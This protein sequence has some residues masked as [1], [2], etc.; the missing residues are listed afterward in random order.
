MLQISYQPDSVFL[1][2]FSIKHT[3]QLLSA[4]SEQ[5][6][7]LNDDQFSYLSI[8]LIIELLRKKIRNGLKGVA[9]NY[10]A[11]PRSSRVDFHSGFLISPF[12]YICMGVRPRTRTLGKQVDDGN[13]FQKFLFVS[14][15]FDQLYFNCTLICYKTTGCHLWP[16]CRRDCEIRKIYQWSLCAIKNYHRFYL[17]GSRRRWLR[18][19]TTPCFSLSIILKC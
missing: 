11:C 2:S 15:G 13:A 7:I 5:S 19:I 12:S 4:F 16:S 8:R 9:N 6:H 17:S 18:K 14:V 1:F 3:N 10:F